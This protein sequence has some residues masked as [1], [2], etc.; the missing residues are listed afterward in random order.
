MRQKGGLDSR[1]DTYYLQEEVI[2]AKLTKVLLL[3]NQYLASIKLTKALGGGY[4]QAN[5]PLVN[6]CGSPLKC[7]VSDNLR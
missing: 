3:Y 7:N 6:R 5:V 1:F 2:Q 4:V